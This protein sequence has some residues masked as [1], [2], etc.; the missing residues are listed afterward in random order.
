LFKNFLTALAEKL[1][2]EDLFTL[3]QDCHS[4]TDYSPCQKACTPEP[5]TQLARIKVC[6]PD[7]TEDSSRYILKQDQPSIIN[8]SLLDFDKN[9]HLITHSVRDPR[10]MLISG[11]F[12]HKKCTQ[13]LEPWVFDAQQEECFPRYWL[14]EKSEEANRAYDETIKKYLLPAKGLTKQEALNSMKKED[15]LVYEMMVLMHESYK[16]MYYWNIAKK[17]AIR[18]GT[19]IESRIKEIK[20]EQVMEDFDSSI[21]E[22]LNFYKIDKTMHDSVL[23]KA[24]DFD[25]A[26]W[27]KKQLKEDSH[28]NF[29]YKK[30]RWKDHFTDEV[31]YLFKL[32]YGDLI[33][34]LGYEKDYNW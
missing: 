27:S 23:E 19:L 8:F 17:E 25:T 5:N 16:R 2:E 15:A 6:L 7:L 3:D 34:D 33:V 29:K 22:L 12:Y 24:R 32:F 11:Y 31:T 21:I 26:S 28:A 4:I 30:D 13:E 10:D 18:E 20:F 1:N 14:R 9:S